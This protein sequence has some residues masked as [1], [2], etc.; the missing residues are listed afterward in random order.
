MTSV[1]NESLIC[2]CDSAE[3]LRPQHF[4][5]YTLYVSLLAYTTTFCLPVPGINNTLTEEC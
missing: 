4:V 2:D 1:Y 5:V 3:I